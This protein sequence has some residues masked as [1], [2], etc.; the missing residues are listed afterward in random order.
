MGIFNFFSNLIKKKPISLPEKNKGDIVY[1]IPTKNGSVKLGEN[2]QVEQGY[3]VVVAHD[4]KV[5]DI[6]NEVG[7]I[8]LEDVTLPRL[9]K[10]RGNM[11]TKRG[12]VAPR[13]LSAD[14]Y[15]VKI[16][17][18]NL[19]FKTHEKVSCKTPNGKM[20]MRITGNFDF[21]IKD[22][23]KFMEALL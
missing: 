23:R 2:I 21:C 18:H 22:M 12:I 8:K 9:F 10:E 20:K 5:L 16:D 13:K 6:I 17:G 14:M 3:N 4:N 1:L 15:F 7:L 19:K 11:L